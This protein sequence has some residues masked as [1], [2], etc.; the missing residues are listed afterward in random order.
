[1][2]LHKMAQPLKKYLGRWIVNVAVTLA[3]ELK[4]KETTK[5]HESND[6]DS[7]SGTTNKG[8]KTLPLKQPKYYF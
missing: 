4:K 5:N 1:M 8:L 2:P 3:L 6:K 7:V